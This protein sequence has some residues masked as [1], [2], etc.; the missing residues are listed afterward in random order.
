M[1]V[2]LAP[3]SREEFDAYV[4]HAVPSY[5][6]AHAK[7]G[8]W[9]EE[10]A[11]AKARKAYEDSLPD[12]LETK[13]HFLYTITDAENATKIGVLWFMVDDSGPSR[14]AFLYELRVWEEFQ[15]RGY[16]RAAMIEM[17][18]ELERR[19]VGRVSLHVFGYN[20]VAIDLYRS[21][22]YTIAD[23][24]MAKKLPTP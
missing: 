14:T 17:E 3:M 7:A 19:Q 1:T 11:L 23:L 9:S 8:N 24:I 5:A 21:L 20:S 10:E 6:A 18:R 12:G 15:R 13:N 16:G 2:K 22:G 4:E